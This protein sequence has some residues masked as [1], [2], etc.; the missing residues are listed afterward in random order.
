[1]PIIVHMLFCNGQ[2]CLAVAGSVMFLGCMCRC[3]QSG[4]V[5]VGVFADYSF[6]G[7]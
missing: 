4:R 2:S 7:L 1:M 5:G 6:A 3:R